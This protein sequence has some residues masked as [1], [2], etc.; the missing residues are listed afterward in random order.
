VVETAM[1][2]CFKDL[3]VAAIQLFFASFEQDSVGSR[4][5]CLRHSSM[6]R[7]VLAGFY[8]QW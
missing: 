6:G 1:G 7:K 2:G 5:V 3:V 4:K 8:D